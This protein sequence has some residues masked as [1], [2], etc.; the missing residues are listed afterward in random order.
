MPK[1][2]IEEKFNSPMINLALD[3]IRM[4]KQALIFVNTKRS[5]EKEAE[6][7]AK[8]I[9]TVS[10][11]HEKIADEAL[12]ALASP[13]EQC[14]RLSE[15]LKKGIAFHHAGLTSK[16]REIVEE[17]FKN[18]TIK[19]ICS[20]PTLAAG[21][22]MPAFRTIIR[23]L[24]RYGHRGLTYIPVL[25]YLQMAGR[26]GR[27]RYDK[28]GESIAIANSEAEAEAITEKYI[29]GEPEEIYSKLAVE[30]VLRTYLLSLIA[31]RFVQ[32]K[33][34]IN[35][36][37]GKT[38]WAHQFK[39]MEKLESN[40]QQMLDLLEEWEFVK[41]EYVNKEDK[42]GKAYEKGNSKADDF[43]DPDFVSAN[44]LFEKDDE[45]KYTATL[46]GKRVAELYIDPL[47]AHYFILCLQKHKARSINAF[48]FLQM[49]SH[50]LEM[51][52]LLHVK[53][54]EQEDIEQQLGLLQEHLIDEEPSFYDS[55]H[56]EFMNSVKTA[57]FFKAWIEEK[58]EQDILDE[59][60]VRPGETR[61]KLDTA[62]WLLYSTEEICK[63]LA[64]KELI[65]EIIKLRFRIR[66]GVKEELLAL[67]R[68]KGIG[69]VRARKLFNNKIKDLGDIK[70]ADISTLTSLLGK[71]I[72]M[73]VKKQVG[74]EIKE[75]PV[76]E[77]K[78][79]EK[80]EDYN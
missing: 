14:K 55:E 54:K 64:F 56:E 60:T 78:L 5:A 69:R 4:E 44:R 34:Q 16:Q 48:S 20:T 2:K 70:K 28:Y 76:P 77:P 46:L 8:K 27:P 68:L 79:G 11:A 9:K 66:Y 40:I 49:V 59:Y 45:I 57:L 80:I 25:E 36:F 41:K 58:T 61:T 15:C 17:N 21:L 33:L 39:D 74:Q 50:T 24:K 62:D 31:S 19:I 51:R 6:E 67:L 65:K 63:L 32:T 35:T 7:I 26:A 73:D 1:E 12:N 72:A 43:V 29:N 47:T 22:D 37:F 71:K 3:T 30:P 38:F 52:P 53:V 42:G 10:E 23:D 13:T 75:K 18:K